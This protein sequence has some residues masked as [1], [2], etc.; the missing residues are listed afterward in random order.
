M[1]VADILGKCI[2]NINS[3][4]KGLSVVVGLQSQIGTAVNILKENEES[5]GMETK[6]VGKQ[7]NDQFSQITKYM[8]D[9][10]SSKRKQFKN[11]SSSYYS[12]TAKLES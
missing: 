5:A 7:L 12:T 10:V 2:D 3:F 4:T 11:Y 6:N 8:S 9:L 1:S